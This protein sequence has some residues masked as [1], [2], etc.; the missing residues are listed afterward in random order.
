MWNLKIGGLKLRL[1]SREATT[2][3]ITLANDIRPD[4]GQV[5]AVVRPL[6]ATF[7]E[8]WEGYCYEH[9][10]KPEMIHF[11]KEVWKAATSSEREACITIAE[12][13]DNLSV[14]EFHRAY[15]CEDV[16]E[17]IRLRYTKAA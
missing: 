2:K 11:A 5:E 10:L 1:T 7:E 8:W 14:Y 17:A 13:Y 9:C 3:E 15:K 4:S 12:D 16:S 6:P